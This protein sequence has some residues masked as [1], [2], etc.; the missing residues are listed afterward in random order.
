MKNVIGFGRKLDNLPKNRVLTPILTYYN[1]TDL[2]ET[3]PD[4]E[5][6]WACREIINT[7][8]ASFV[9]TSENISYRVSNKN[10]NR[11]LLTRTQEDEITKD[12]VELIRAKRVFVL[13]GHLGPSELKK[14]N[15]ELETTHATT[16]LTNKVQLSPI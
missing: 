11:L 9:N 15:S 14:N 1:I 10:L 7:T 2:T 5:K 8:S 13:G 6:R 4:Q 12:Y 3:L 16:N